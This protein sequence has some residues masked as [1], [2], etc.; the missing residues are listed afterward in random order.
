M[1]KNEFQEKKSVDRKAIPD[2]TSLIN[3]EF[4]KNPAFETEVEHICGLLANG[5]TLKRQIGDK[6]DHKKGKAG[7][8]LLREL[9]A[10]TEE[11]AQIQYK[12]EFPGIRNGRYVFVAR[13]QEGRE[14]LQKDQLKQQLL[15]QLG[16]VVKKG[17][18]ILVIVNAC[19]EAATKTGDAFMVRELEILD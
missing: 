12:H 4:P 18:D 15:A 16:P 19:F 1:A 6:P 3:S 17:T 5:A 10:I 14:T 7:S 8:G 13:Y 9:D 2:I 11:L